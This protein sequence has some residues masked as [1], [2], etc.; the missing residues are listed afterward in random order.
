MTDKQNS[1]RAE[2][3]TLGEKGAAFFDSAS[4]VL[5]EMGHGS[6]FAPYSSPS[7]WEVL[8]QE[9]KEISCGLRE[10]LVKL[11]IGI[12]DAAKLSPLL[13]TADLKQIRLSLREMSASLRFREFEHHDTYVITEEDRAYGMIPEEE[14]EGKTSVAA[15]ASQFRRASENLLEKLDF[16]LPSPEKLSRAIVAAETAAVRRYRSNTAF[17]MMQIDDKNPRL[18]DIKWC[19]KDVFICFGID[20]VRS[21]E[22]EHQDVL[23]QRILDEIATSKFL[24]ADLTGERPSVY[25]E[26]EFAH[27]C[28]KRLILY[29]EKG[30]QLHFDLSVHNVPEYENITDLKSKL[31]KRL[32]AITNKP[33]KDSAPRAARTN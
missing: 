3:G 21:D 20:A 23:T 6:G 17:I 11:G 31:T 32:E 25:Y 26:V 14:T 13:G 9:L 27:A 4:S 2:L 8:P 29:R 30:T 33:G 1:I 19:I 24:I 16:T 5:E 15:A 22:I 10:R 12:L 18:E 28:G 7:S